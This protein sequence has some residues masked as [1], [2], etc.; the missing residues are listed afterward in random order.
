MTRPFNLLNAE[1]RA[2]VMKHPV[3]G[4]N[5]LMAVDRLKDAA[6]L[7]RHHHECFDGSGFPDHLVGMAIPLGSRILAVANDY[8][9]LQIG[10]LVQRPLRPSEALTFLVD[11]RGK[12][13]DPQVVDVV[14]E[15]IEASR[16]STYEEVPVR[17]TLLRP[18]MVLARDFHHKDGYL[19]LA[20]ATALTADMI[21]QL[22]KMETIEQFKITLWIRQEIA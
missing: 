10:T 9:A 4:Q 16:T 5:I 15:I 8:D 2:T 7:V 18:G 13:Y 14:A 19:L 3:I 20:R 22:Q 21:A 6:V 11:N 12:R 17:A 1:H